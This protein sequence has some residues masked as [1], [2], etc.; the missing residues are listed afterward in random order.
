MTIP[1]RKF[2]SF[3]PILHQICSS[4]FITDRWISLL[5]QC[6]SEDLN[7][8]WRNRAW[9]QF[10]LLSKLCQLVNQTVTVAVNQFLLQS[11]VVS[12]V[13]TDIDFNAQI[14]KVISQFY[15]STIIYF[16]HLIDAVNLHMHIDQPFMA[17]SIAKYSRIGFYLIQ[18]IQTDTTNNQQLREVCTFFL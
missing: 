8:D 14:E 10:R 5:E 13:L 17:R 9:K 16:R 6:T 7:A 15:Q 1:Y 12:N 3:S 18:D 4:D 11:F 2:M